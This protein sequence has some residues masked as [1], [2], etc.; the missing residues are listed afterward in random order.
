MWSHTARP[1]CCPHS[2]SAADR[3]WTEETIVIEHYRQE[4]STTH[5]FLSLNACRNANDIIFI[6]HD[7]FVQIKWWVRLVI[8]PSDGPK[9]KDIGNCS[10]L[11]TCKLQRF[12]TFAWSFHYSIIKLVGETFS[13]DELIEYLFQHEKPNIVLYLGLGYN[14]VN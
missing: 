1:L 14:M 9:P 5:W 6:N 3:C 8:C 12:L 7:F 10:Y 11:I 4:R 2:N 13:M